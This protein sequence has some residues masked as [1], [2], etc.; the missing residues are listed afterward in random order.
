MHLRNIVCCTSLAQEFHVHES[1]EAQHLPRDFPFDEVPGLSNEMIER[2][3]LA[4]PESLA[5]AGRIRGIT[6]AAL[7]ALLVHARKLD[8]AA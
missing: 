8:R 7:A 3:S 1:S 4:R 6:P 5:A 2:L